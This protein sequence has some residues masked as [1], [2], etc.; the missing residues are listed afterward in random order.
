[1]WCGEHGCSPRVRH[2]R[3]GTLRVP[4][5]VQSTILHFSRYVGLLLRCCGGQGAHAAKTMEPRG[6]SWVAAGFSSYD[7]D[8]RL[9]LVFALGSPNFPLSCEGKLGV[10]GGLQSMGSQRVRH[11]WVMEHVSTNTYA[12]SVWWILLQPEVL[13]CLWGIQVKTYGLEHDQR[14]GRKIKMWE[15]QQH[16]GRREKEV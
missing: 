1:M 6:F 14:F 10:V 8:F 11:D 7:G 5:W 2:V 4:S 16:E 12:I 3:W 13:R 15:S 9:P